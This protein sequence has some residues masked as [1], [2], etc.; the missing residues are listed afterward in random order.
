MLSVSSVLFD[1][2]GTLVD[3]AGAITSGIRYALRTHGLPD[4]GEDRVAALI[5]P[6]LHI[7]LRTLAG[8]DDANIDQIIATYREQYARQGMAQSQIYPGITQLLAQL[9]DAGMYLAV[10]TAKPEPIA[11]QL[12][13][14]QGLDSAFDAVH[15]NR[16]EVGEHGSSKAHIVAAAVQRADLN[17]QSCVVVG[18]RYYDLEAARDNQIRSI[19]VRWGFAQGSELAVADH[20]VD[21]TSELAALLLGATTPSALKNDVEPQEGTN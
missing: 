16:G 14:V 10:T 20:V 8:V 18:D 19:G 13:E 12:L 4:P 9:R 1:L 21:N 5:G 2:D 7:G 6:P 3:P 15:G 11:R 17:P